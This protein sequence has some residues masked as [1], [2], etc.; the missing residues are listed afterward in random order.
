LI[1][2]GTGGTY[3]I[4]DGTGEIWVV[5]QRGV[6]QK[7]ARLK[8]KGK[9]QNGVTFNGTNYGLVLYEDDRDFQKK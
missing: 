2:R 3:K 7:G 8:V 9:I 4:D 1:R 5:T 6:P